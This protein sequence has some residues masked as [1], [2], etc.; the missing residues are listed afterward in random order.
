VMVNLARN[1]AIRRLLQ[2]ASSADG[3]TPQTSLTPAQQMLEDTGGLFTVDD[4]GQVRPQQQ[5]QQEP[6]A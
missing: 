5:R 6:R 1:R 2:Q 4:K 3:Q